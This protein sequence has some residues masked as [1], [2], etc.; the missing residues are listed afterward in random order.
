MGSGF[1]V[2]A[3]AGMARALSAVLKLALAVGLL[4]AATSCGDES[5][6]GTYQGYIEGDYLYISS[7]SGGKVERISVEKGARV[8][9]GALLYELDQE[10]EASSYQE[11]ES[12]HSAAK[13]LYKDKTK[14]RRP[15]E[16]AAIEASI[17]QAEARL[18]FSE[19]EF[20]RLGSLHE[21]EAIPEER[22]DS[23]QA[24]YARDRAAVAELKETLKT[25]RLGDRTGQLEAA[26]RQVEKTKAAL[27]MAAWSLAQ[28]RGIAPAP[29]R[30]V[31]VLYYEGEYVPAGY[32]VVVLLPADKVKA[33]FF[34]P[35]PEL[36]ALRTGQEVTIKIDGIEG[37][38]VGTISY[39]SP[40]AEY[41]PPFIY[42]KDSRAKL[43][44]MVEAYFAPDVAGSLNPGQPVEVRAGQ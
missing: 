42:S 9:A 10:P 6:R 20:R 7:P 23:A 39:I 38:I 18:A 21:K 29:A 27:D 36:S 1:L 37:P 24:A 43:V 26:Q 2:K 32:P 16:I 31:D 28:K 3:G 33:R 40:K 34:V 15:T 22:L 25:A 30:V 12:L 13:A 41:T 17:A 8:E 14:G 4:A 5:S 19:K 35:E 11:A 44:F